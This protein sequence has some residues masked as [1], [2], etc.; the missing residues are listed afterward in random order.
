MPETVCLAFTGASGMPY[1]VRLLECLLAAGCRVQLLYSQVAQIVARQEMG[2]DLPARASEA[3]AGL[4]ERYPGLP[5]QL[6]VYGREEWFAPLASGSNPPDAMVICPCSLGTLAAI[7]QGLASKL[8]ERA[9]DV[10]LKEGRKLILV[11]R[12]TP[13][14]V[15]HLENMLRLARAGAVILPPS[16]GFYHHPQRVGDLVDFVVAR[17]L[18]QLQVRHALM[19]RWG[20]APTAP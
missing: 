18:D 13:L 4:E 6:E 14:S 20:E 3:R 15:I 19:P 12:E 1:G 16:P 10:V 11:P 5:G 2:L 17:I 7:A 9:A 8:I